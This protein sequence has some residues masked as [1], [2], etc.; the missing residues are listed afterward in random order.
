M[1][2]DLQIEPTDN[3]V[4]IVE[5]LVN[6]IIVETEYKIKMKPVMIEKTTERVKVIVLRVVQKKIQII[7][8][9]ETEK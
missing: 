6:L 2:I 5:I 3:V 9:A 4:K 7:Q 1:I 8:V